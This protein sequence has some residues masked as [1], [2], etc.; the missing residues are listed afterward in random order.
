ML[1][2]QLE[3]LP[4]QLR[5]VVLVSEEVIQ[6]LIGC[7]VALWRVISEAKAVAS[8]ASHRRHGETILKAETRGHL[9][10]GNH[11][12]SNALLGS[13]VW[14]VH[15]RSRCKGFDARAAQRE[16]MTPFPQK[17][18]MTKCLKT[19]ERKHVSPWRSFILLKQAQLWESCVDSSHLS[20]LIVAL[21]S[22]VLGFSRWP[23]GHC[24]FHGCMFWV[25]ALRGIAPGSCVVKC[26][27]CSCRHL[28]M[29]D[30][31]L[32]KQAQFWKS[33]VDSSN[34]S[35]LI[36]TLLADVLGFPSNIL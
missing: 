21:L 11:G 24:G 32:L 4:L 23:F 15:L 29:A 3:S 28:R 14:I 5:L 10:F 22:D 34:L 33:C 7:T 25:G 30:W 26:F 27:D 19:Q 12:V 36:D 31:I 17:P 16:A 35:F 13:H 9:C 18:T 8:W 2:C 6:L 1:R 20:F